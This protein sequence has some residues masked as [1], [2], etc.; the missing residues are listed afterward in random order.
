[1]T[2]VIIKDWR[3][4][5]GNSQ[6]SSN[7]IAAGVDSIIKGLNLNIHWR[8]HVRVR[9]ENVN[10]MVEFEGEDAEEAAHMISWMFSFA[11]IVDDSFDSETI[12]SSDTTK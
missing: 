1:M 8:N 12:T 3:V 9:G 2:K 6:A 10:I 7:N 5:E 4:R 11:T